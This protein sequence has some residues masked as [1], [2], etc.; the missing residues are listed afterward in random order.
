MENSNV[1]ALLSL[2]CLFTCFSL[3]GYH[4]CCWA[5][6]KEACHFY[7]HVCV[8][9][10]MQVRAGLVRQEGTTLSILSLQ[11]VLVYEACMR[12]K[13][14]KVQVAGRLGQAG[15]VNS[16]NLHERLLSHAKDKC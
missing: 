12:R 3:Q 9:V 5:R 4:I 13:G 1:K 6:L 11:R 7:R 2:K 8:C 15:A 14:E 10:H 16:L